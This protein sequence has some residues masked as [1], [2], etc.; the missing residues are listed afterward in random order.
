MKF[1]VSLY[2]FYRSIKMNGLSPMDCI[3]KAKE[4]GFDAV[5]AVDFVNFDCPLDEMP[6]RAKEIKAEADRCGLAISS[7][8]I[9]ADLIHGCDGD[10]KAEIQRIKAFVDAAAS[11]GA[12][13]MRHDITR[14]YNRESGKACSYETLV[15]M[16]AESCREIAEYAQSKGVMTMTENHG[17]FSQDSYRVEALF[18]AVAHPN[19]ALLCDMGNFLCADENPALSVARVAPYTRYVHAKDFVVKSYADANPGEGSFQS[20]GGNYLRGTIIGH[21]NVP[22]KQCLHILHASGYDDTIAI[23]FE[24]MELPED[25]LR[26]GLANLKRYW[27]EVTA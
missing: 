7:L 18:N 16:L 27:S 22:V 11:M 6:A 14:G 8:A 25:A 4:M 24:G 20:R 1:S 19:F 21:G 17:F 13:K 26:I 5:E 2:S 23:E 9:G 10:T 12:P 3:A 15:P